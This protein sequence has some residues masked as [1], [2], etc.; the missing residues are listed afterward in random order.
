ML[1]LWKA[2]E[3]RLWG[4]SPRPYGMAPWA[5]ALDRSAKASLGKTCNL[6]V[7]LVLILKCLSVPHHTSSI[8]SAQLCSQLGKLRVDNWHWGSN[9][10]VCSDNDI[11]YDTVLYFTSASTL[12]HGILWRC[13]PV[14]TVLVMCM[15]WP[16]IVTTLL[17]RMCTVQHTCSTFFVFQKCAQMFL[18]LLP[19]FFSIK[20]CGLELC[21]YSRTACPVS[22][23]TYYT[24]SDF[25]VFVGNG[26]W[27][28]CCKVVSSM[29]A[30]AMIPL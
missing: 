18:G 7:T 9:L 12:S 8:S 24:D 25:H 4:S 21:P 6:S 20:I 17:G 13:S 5:T 10:E 28:P 3:W 19:S 15:L 14:Y 11:V 22:R 2:E 29:R 26:F 1:F 27:C 30:K 16:W 23:Y